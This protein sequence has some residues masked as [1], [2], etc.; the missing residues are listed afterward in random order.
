[1]WTWVRLG[2]SEWWV[3]GLASSAALTESFFF[4]LLSLKFYKFRNF[5]L[6]GFFIKMNHAQN[7]TILIKCSDLPNA[8]LGPPCGVPKHM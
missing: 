6:M 2:S 3:L 5:Y 1:M 4:F 7:N 8:V